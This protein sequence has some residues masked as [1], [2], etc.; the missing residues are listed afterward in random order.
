MIKPSTTIRTSPVQGKPHGKPPSRFRYA[1]EPGTGH[2]MVSTRDPHRCQHPRPRPPRPPSTPPSTAAAYYAGPS[3]GDA[4]SSFRIPIPSAGAIPLAR[5][6]AGGVSDG[7][8]GG[9]VG[10]GGSGSGAGLWAGG[11]VGWAAVRSAWARSA[12]RAR[13]AAESAGRAAAVSP[14]R[15]PARA[16]PTN[17]CSATRRWRVPRPCRPGGRAPYR[18]WPYG[19]ARRAALRRSRR[20]RRRAG[21]RSGL[22]AERDGAG[23]S[24]S[25]PTLMQPAEA[26]TASDV[27]IQT[28]IRRPGADNWRTSGTSG[29]RGSPRR[30]R[31][32]NRTAQL[33]FPRRGH[34][35]T[36][37]VPRPAP[38][39]ALPRAPPDARSRNQERASAHTARASSA[40]RNTA[41]SPIST[42]AVT[43]TAASGP[44]PRSASRSV[45][46]EKVEYVVSAPHSPVP[47]RAYVPEETAAPAPRPAPGCRPR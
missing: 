9:F 15:A 19:R 38:S 41:P 17:W 33:T 10:S 3:C 43:F 27:A 1:Q 18:P 37:P 32:R 40:P 47:S 11:G 24:P 44:R 8:V 35:R 42:D 4:S 26:A 2:R 39:D 31:G 34:A 21:C 7:C 30:R 46:Y 16:W 22:S 13:R 23:R 5:T 20:W 29:A 25:S 14:S 36:R 6:S 45:S 28:A 12:V